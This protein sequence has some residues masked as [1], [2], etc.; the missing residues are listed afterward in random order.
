MTKRH[1]PTR[2]L[3]PARASYGGRRDPITV[4]MISIDRLVER[5]VEQGAQRPTARVLRCYKLFAEWETHALCLVF[6]D[7]Q[8]TPA[9]HMELVEACDARAGHDSAAAAAEVINLFAGLALV[10]VVAA[11]AFM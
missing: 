2:I 5:A 8:I 3:E 9:Q 6:A 11:P 10:A 7:E 4:H 1:T